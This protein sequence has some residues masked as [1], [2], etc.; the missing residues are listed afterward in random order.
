VS[1]SAFFKTDTGKFG[2]SGAVFSLLAKALTDKLKVA[3][4]VSKD[5]IISI[6]GYLIVKSIVY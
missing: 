1:I 4:I 5:L 6:L 3:K 2:I